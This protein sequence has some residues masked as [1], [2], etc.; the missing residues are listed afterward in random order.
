M[1]ELLIKVKPF[2]GYILNN[3]YNSFVARNTGFSKDSA[4]FVAFMRYSANFLGTKLI[5]NFSG[6]IVQGAAGS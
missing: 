2:D 3:C 5:P 4:T 1:E 6:F